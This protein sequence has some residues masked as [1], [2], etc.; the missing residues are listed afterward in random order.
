MI[1]KLL[2][3]GRTPQKM[4]S[5]FEMTRIDNIIFKLVNVE[6]MCF[7][8]IYILKNIIINGDW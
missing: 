6:Q 5:I 7:F 8:K 3:S 1:T 2:L 4:R